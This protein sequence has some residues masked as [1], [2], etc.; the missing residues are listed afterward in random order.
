MATV[1]D[2]L[3][4]KKEQDPSLAYMGYS[5]I[6]NKLKQEGDP[7]LPEWDLKPSGQTHR[8]P[9]QTKVEPGFVNSL[10]DW[11]DWGIDEGSAR[12]AKSAYNN[13]I[14]GLAYNYYNVHERFDLDGYEPKFTPTNSFFG[15][16]A[17]YI[18]NNVGYDPKL[19]T[20]GIKLNI[21]QWRRPAPNTIP[22]D[23]KASGL[24]M[25]CT[26]SKHEA[27]RKGYTDSLMLD[28]EGNI[29]EATG[30]NIFFKDKKK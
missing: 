10:F 29:A 9:Y 12:W 18:K 19:K 15:G 4:S 16:T 7:N 14:T 30:A 2:Y 21:S 17:I 28:H 1:I 24:Y 8:H 3:K 20:E 25:I 11:T 5:G 6:Y 13:S 27:E 26:L 22:W 23:T